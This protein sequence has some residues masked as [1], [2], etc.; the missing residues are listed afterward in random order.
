VELNPRAQQR[1]RQRKGG[2]GGNQREVQGKSKNERTVASF[3]NNTDLSTDIIISTK[4]SV[5][6]SLFTFFQALFFFNPSFLEGVDLPFPS[7]NR[8][9]GNSVYF[10]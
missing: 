7:L 4:S 9:V 3:C 1:Q 10:V 2:G 8:S 5:F 6:L